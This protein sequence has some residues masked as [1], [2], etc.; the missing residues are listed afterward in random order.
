MSG[1]C[2]EARYCMKCWIF[3]LITLFYCTVKLVLKACSLPSARGSISLHL[4]HSNLICK[5]QKSW[6]MIAR[7]VVDWQVSFGEYFACKIEQA[8]WIYCIYHGGVPAL[9]WGFFRCSVQILHTTNISIWSCL[10]YPVLQL[11]LEGYPL[12]T[13]QVHLHTKDLKFSLFNSLSYVL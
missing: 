8:F 9:I 5:C 6:G 2:L 3:F 4:F 12:L 11:W 1:I 7:R 10:L 13:I